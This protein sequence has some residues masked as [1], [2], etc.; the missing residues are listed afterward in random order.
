MGQANFNATLLVDYVEQKE[1]ELMEELC[2][3]PMLDAITPM[4][5]WSNTP[6]GTPRRTPLP[7]PHATPLLTPRGTPSRGTPSLPR[8]SYGHDI[9]S[10]S[11]NSNYGE[12]IIVPPP[13]KRFVQAPE[14]FSSF[15]SKQVEEGS[16]VELKCFVSCAPLTTTTWEKDNL[17]LVSNPQLMLSEKTGVRTLII[18]NSKLGDAGA[19]RMTITNS[20]GVK[21]CT[22]IL[23]VKKKNSGPSQYYASSQ[24]S[25]PRSPYSSL[26]RSSLGRSSAS[27]SNYTSYRSY[28]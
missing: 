28:L 27:Y 22:A 15:S 11:R 3:C 13:R 16:S 18:H 14:I 19:Y 1:S 23:T 25:V 6:I 20:S 5:S 10:P 26:G 8:R 9:R 2:N 12:D 7:T 21:S 4:M 24:L 17:P